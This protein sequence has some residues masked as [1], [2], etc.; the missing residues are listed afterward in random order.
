MSTHRCRGFSLVEVLIALTL[1]LVLLAVLI[2]IFL[3]VKRSYT[4]Q[5]SL[6]HMQENARVALRLIAHDVRMAG[7]R[8]DVVPS[9]SVGESTDL[10]L[11]AVTGECH[12]AWA[13]L[14]VVPTDGV[15][16]P[17]LTGTNGNRDA[18]NACIAS[19]DYSAGSDILSVYFADGNPVATSAIEA[20][21]VYLRGNL[22]GGLIFLANDN[23]ALPT[24]FTAADAR[25]YRLIAA[26]YY[27]RP[28]SVTAPSKSNPT[29]DGI[30]SLMRATLSDCGAKAC[31]KTEALVEGIANLQVQFG[32]DRGDGQGVR[33]YLNADQLGDFTQANGK[34]QWRQVSAVRVGL[35]VRSL[36]AQPDYKDPNAPYHLGD[37]TVSVANGYRHIWLTSTVARRNRG[38]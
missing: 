6:A 16:A 31:V 13:R 28:W 29:G 38:G 27:L 34:A 5:D 7:Y 11:G 10:P 8:G 35:L 17:S 33:D 23:R 15:I 25:N 14:F 37:Q 3:S 19:S 18:F 30:P 2:S 32:L 12:A 21:K 9:W 4:V 26:T 22:L 36:T 20:G 24:D 1:G